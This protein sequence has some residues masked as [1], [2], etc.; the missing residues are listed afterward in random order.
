M[1][2][3]VSQDLLQGCYCLRKNAPNIHIDHALKGESLPPTVLI[4]LSFKQWQFKEIT[5]YATVLD[6][7]L[8]SSL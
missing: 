6:P 5:T 3:T 8:P 4:K 1:A 2:C 7:T